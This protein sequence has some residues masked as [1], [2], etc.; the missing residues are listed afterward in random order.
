MLVMAGLVVFVY[1]GFSG[2]LPDDDTLKQLR[3]PLTTYVYA[4][5]GS[6]FGK[7]YKENRSEVPLEA[8]P[9]FLTDALIATEDV[10]FY[11]HH[12]VD[13]RS[14]LRI[15]F[16]G[17]LSFGNAGGGSTLTQQLAKNMFPRERYLVLSTP[18]NKL[19]EIII[20][21][22]IEGVYVKEEILDMYLNTV[23][24]G[25]LAYGIG[26]ASRR[27]FNCHPKD[28]R[29]EQAAAL[30]GMLK[31]PS[32]Y[33]P[34]RYPERSLA[35]RNVVLRQMSKYDYLDEEIADSLK[36]LP[37]GLEYTP[38]PNVT[39]LSGYF[40]GQVKRRAQEI[41]DNTPELSFSPLS[42]EIDGLKIYT[43]LDP[44]IQQYA[45]KAVKFIMPRLQA[46]FNKEWGDRAEWETDAWIN[47]SLQELGSYRNAIKQGMDEA[48]AMEVVSRKQE[49]RVFSWDEA[50]SM[51]NFSVIDS[52]LYYKRML[53]T[54]LI[55]LDPH[56]GQVKAWIGGI[57]YRHF[58]YD[59]VFAQRQVGSTFK[60]FVYAAALE[61][62]VD[63]CKYYDNT[64]VVFTDFKDWSPKNANGEYG[65]AY[66]LEGGLAHSVN[67][68]TVQVM[69]DAG[70]RSVVK[71]AKKLG[72]QSTVPDLPSI[73]L[74]TPSLQLGELTAAY[75]AF[76]NGGHRVEPYSILKIEDKNG[77]VLYEHE[78][79][80]PEQVISEELARQMIGLLQ[81]VVEQGTGRRLKYEYGIE[82]PVA[83]KT[84]TTQDHTDG[85]FIGASPDLIVGVWVGADDPRVHFRYLGSGQGGATALAVFG[86]M[87]RHIQKDQ[88]F[89]AWRSREFYPEAGDTTELRLHCP[90]YSDSSAAE[91]Q[92][93]VEALRDIREEELARA[94]STN[95]VEDVIGAI[96][97]NR[98]KS[99]EEQERDLLQ[100]MNRKLDRRTVRMQ[101][102]G[103]SPMEI[104]RELE[105][106]RAEYYGKIRALR[107][108]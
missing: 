106:I 67:T 28:L 27:F 47:K 92:L 8:C 26:T 97:Q 59:R 4:A 99:P 100:E 16:K 69:M 2:P 82:I 76:A 12:G 41:L 64:Q 20:A 88:Q 46:T 31:A 86:Q 81:N 14:Y 39:N 75:G 24:F 9:E 60:P 101:K 94:T 93:Y 58:P 38:E 74:G 53:Q 56:T 62:G 78:G 51:R 105:K 44:R 25:E 35:R 102:Q 85:W 71:M 18:V 3:Q 15:L 95:W 17:V 77:N 45:E 79:S 11:K 29:P 66:S 65:G 91:M 89:S 1:A 36:L 6:V 73:A 68:V 107:E 98:N 52:L 13:Y 50:Q 87:F 19:R 40:L 30:V 43:T 90:L 57:D 48:K 70:I 21:R 49:S 10:R 32:Y 7:I 42:V 104:K 5:D 84:G 23:P 83:G 108:E 80:K 55:A 37:L 103:K 34:R 22:R 54:G 72:I 96:F 63:R 33:S 61:E